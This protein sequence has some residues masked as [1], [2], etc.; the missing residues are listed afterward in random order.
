M[1]EFV[2]DY[3]D[4]IVKLISSIEVTDKKGKIGV[5]INTDSAKEAGLAISAKL[6]NLATIVKS[7]SVTENN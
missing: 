4:K 1:R 6:L 2:N 5:E 7:H 3:F